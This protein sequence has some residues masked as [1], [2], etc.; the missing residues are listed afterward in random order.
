MM[1]HPQKGPLLLSFPGSL[2]LKTLCHL[3][4]INTALLYPL[5]FLFSQLLTSHQRA[6]A[7]PKNITLPVILYVY[8]FLMFHLLVVEAREWCIIG[9]I[10]QK[11]IADQ[12]LFLKMHMSCWLPTAQQLLQIWDETTRGL[13]IHLCHS[14]VSLIPFPDTS[15]GQ[16]PLPSTTYRLG[17]KGGDGVSIYYSAL[18]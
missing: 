11:S 18:Q 16:R 6:G 7:Q 3:L 5:V 8:L 4:N 15:G 10:S 14:H 13:C 2:I 9:N 17:Q 12:G 1:W